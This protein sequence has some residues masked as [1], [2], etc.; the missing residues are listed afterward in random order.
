MK[1]KVIIISILLLVVGFGAYA[2]VFRRR[3]Q[4]EPTEP[5]AGSMD[6]PPTG[7][8]PTQKNFKILEFNCR[9]GTPVPTAYYGNLQRLMDNLQ[10]LRDHVKLPIHVNSGYRTPTYNKKIGGAPGSA[11]LRAMASDITIPGYTPAKIK[12]TIED[13]IA[14][15]KMQDGGIGFYSTFIH[16]DVSRPR[17]WN[18]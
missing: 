10:V 7:G 18:G 9:D 13:L 16:Y 11:H 6:Y 15:G 3:E 5:N 2:F 4:P 8:T 17:R 14:D 1:L 12:S